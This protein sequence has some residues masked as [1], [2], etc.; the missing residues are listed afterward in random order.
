MNRFGYVAARVWPW[1]LVGLLTIV[2]TVLAMLPAAWITPQFALRTG[3]RVVLADP[4][5]SLWHGSA[6]LRLAAGSDSG[7]ATE[8][9]G[10]LEW[11]T[12]FWPLMT[13]RVHMTLDQTA[14]MPAPVELV[15]TLRQA[16]LGAGSLDVPASLLD[17]LGAPFN[18]LALRGIVRLDWN[19]WRVFGPNAFGRMTVT[20]SD[21][22]SR[23][24]RVRPLGAYQVIYEAQGETGTLQ[25]KTLKGPLILEGQ[26]D[27]RDRR[28]AFNGDARA[29]PAVAENLRSFLDL[30][31]RRDPDGSYALVFNR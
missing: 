25:L 9:P 10:R 1:V 20:L 31:G 30:L 4:S 29:D 27:M 22:A 3:G 15:A 6:T 21:I 19:E 14:A 24:S 8:L 11:T 16:T 13:G 12:A 18:T 23:V 5:G 7:D 17:G 2:I 26:G 28:L